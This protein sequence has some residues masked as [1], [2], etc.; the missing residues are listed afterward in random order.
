MELK[1][2]QKAFTTDSK[3]L[4]ALDESNKQD[5]INRA[6]QDELLEAAKGLESQFIQRLLTELR[7][8]VPE[9]ELIPKSNAERIYE[10]M[11]FDEYSQKMANAGG[12][13]LSSLIVEQLSKR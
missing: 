12:I 11:L 3:A 1:G 5:K 7:K 4:G 10:D 13:G 8:T 6:K 9:N 2:V